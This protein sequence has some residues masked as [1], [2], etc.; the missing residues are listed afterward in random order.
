MSEESSIALHRSFSMTATTT[1]AT[2]AFFLSSRV[3]PF[4]AM[5][6]M[7]G[8]QREAKTA[9]LHIRL[10]GVVPFISTTSTVRAASAVSPAARYDFKAASSPGS[11]KTFSCSSSGSP[12]TSCMTVTR[13][14]EGS[15]GKLSMATRW[16]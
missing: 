15:A 14:A 16:L 1:R 7:E 12:L 3:L 11:C 6:L 2:Q 13:V 4:A 9:A 8:K 5:S 10:V